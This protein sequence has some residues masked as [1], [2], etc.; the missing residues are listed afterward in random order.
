M[1]TVIM[2][3]LKHVNLPCDAATFETKLRRVDRNIHTVSGRTCTY[4]HT[5]QLD[6]PIRLTSVRET[7]S[8]VTC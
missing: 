4:A 5:S 6:S 1:D 8:A 2:S 7:T 3:S